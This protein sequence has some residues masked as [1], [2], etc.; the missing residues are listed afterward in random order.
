LHQKRARAGVHALAMANNEDNLVVPPGAERRQ[1]PLKSV[2][3][4]VAAPMLEDMQS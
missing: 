4:D 1:F 2:I 3:A